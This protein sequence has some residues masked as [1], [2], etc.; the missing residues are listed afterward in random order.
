LQLL[1]AIFSAAY[2]QVLTPAVSLSA[3]STNG[4]AVS[5]VLDSTQAQYLTGALTTKA[6]AGNTI[7]STVFVVPGTK[8]LIFP[9]GFIITSV[10]AVIGIAAV[11]YGTLGRL[12]FRDQFRKSTDRAQ[13][14]AQRFI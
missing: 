2:Q 5:Q 4:T 10:W 3:K 1:T 14:S 6:V 12:S 9:V 11:M 13:K 8:L 7:P